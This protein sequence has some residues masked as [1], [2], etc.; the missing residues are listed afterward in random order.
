MYEIYLST[1]KLYR[2]VIY[3]RYTLTFKAFPAHVNV[4]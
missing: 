1:I 2:M 4:S 3:F